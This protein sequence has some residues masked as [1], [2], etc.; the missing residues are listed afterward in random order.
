[1]KS[2]IILLTFT[3]LLSVTT[4]GQNLGKGS[5]G[6]SY[7]FGGVSLITKKNFVKELSANSS[8]TVGLVYLHSL[9]QGVELESGLTYSLFNY[10]NR[11]TDS[12]IGENDFNGNICII[13]IPIGIRAT[14][15]K[16]FFINGGGLIDFT[17]TNSLPISSQSGIGL[18]GGLGIV[19]NYNFGGSLYLNP[20]L[21]FHSLIPFG[22]WNDQ[23]RIFETLGVK[24]GFTYKL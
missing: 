7:S 10:Y 11:K 15:G 1:M 14:F 22:N 6:L 13:D 12:E 17:T 21:K 20:Y 24:I 4:F 2:K 8:R 3:T 9:T 18:Y 23:D 19:A 16:Y 5:I